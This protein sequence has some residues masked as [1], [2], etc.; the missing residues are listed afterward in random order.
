M[1]ASLAKKK[2]LEFKRKFFSKDVAEILH[3]IEYA[4]NNGNYS[5]IIL[6]SFN[7]EEIKFMKKLG[8]K[9]KK[10]FPKDSF[11]QLEISWK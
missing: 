6:R 2:T 11:P 5:F 3:H 9:F 10:N 1:K 8:Y 4:A 7:D